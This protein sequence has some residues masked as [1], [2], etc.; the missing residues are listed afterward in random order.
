AS[1]ARETAQSDPPFRRGEGYLPSR[2]G[3]KR[4]SLPTRRRV[5]SLTTRGKATSPSDAAEGTFPHDA[6]E[7]DLPFRRGGG[8]LPSRRGGKRPLLPTRRRVPSLTTR[9]KAS[10]RAHSA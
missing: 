8:Y 1:C 7:S 9:G 3:G 10:A 4:P 6:G 5:P 2:R